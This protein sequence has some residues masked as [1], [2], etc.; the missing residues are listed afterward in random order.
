MHGVMCT[1]RSWRWQSAKGI[2]KRRENEL[3]GYENWQLV[4]RKR[5]H[6]LPISKRRRRRPKETNCEGQLLGVWDRDPQHAPQFC[7]ERQLEEHVSLWNLGDESNL[8]LFG[9]RLASF[10][11]L[12][13]EFEWLCVF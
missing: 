2:K 8:V 7:G 1:Q 11:Q 9:K 12:P 6:S 3:P 4:D 10:H 13:F 5:E